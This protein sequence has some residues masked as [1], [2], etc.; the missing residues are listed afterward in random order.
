MEHR[1]EQSTAWIDDVSIEEA[2]VVLGMSTM[3][4]CSLLESGRLAGHLGPDG[5]RRRIVRAD[6]ETHRDTRFAQRQV[7][8]QEVR[9]RRWADNSDVSWTDNE[10]PLDDLI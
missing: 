9:A 2:A 6:L 3:A 10:I 8:V 4:V 5:R 1:A 7:R